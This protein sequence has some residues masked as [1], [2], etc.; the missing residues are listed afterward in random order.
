LA[1]KSI[2]LP[3]IVTIHSIIVNKKQQVQ[4]YFFL[5]S[6]GMDPPIFLVVQ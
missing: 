6:T 1:M 2:A 4:V 5:P 3:K